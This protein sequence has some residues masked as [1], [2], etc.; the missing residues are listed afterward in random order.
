MYLDLATDKPDLALKHVEKALELERGSVPVLAL[1]TSRLLEAYLRSLLQDH[2]SA[3][4]ILRAALSVQRVKAVERRDWL[5]QVLIVLLYNLAVAHHALH[6]RKAAIHYIFRAEQALLTR[7]VCD[8]SVKKCVLTLKDELIVPE[9]AVGL[10]SFTVITERTQLPLLSGSRRTAT[11]AKLPRM[12]TLQRST[13]REHS[14][15]VSS[16]RER[17]RFISVQPV[18]RRKMK[19]F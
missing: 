9:T 7:D 17:Q 4:S 13:S 12:R 6:L 8:L 11:E 3:V 2:K 16:S 5:H 19:A 1:V 15:E 14:F 10:H 18:L